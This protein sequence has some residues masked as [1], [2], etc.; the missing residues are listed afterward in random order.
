MKSKLVI[1]NVEKIT[2]LKYLNA[3][4]ITY[5]NKLGQEKKWELVSRQGLERLEKELYE[6]KVFSDGAMIFATNTE[7]THVVML[8][9]FRVSAGKYIYMVPAGLTDPGETIEQTSTRE[10]LE[11]TG[12]NFEFVKSAP[13]RYA[14]VG[15]VN[16]RVEI[17]YGYYHGIPNDHHMSVDEDA[18]VV[19]VDKEM[20]VQILATE[21]VSIR[22]ALLLEN[23][24]GLNDFF[25]K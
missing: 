11:E 10:F 5:L 25:R 17:A 4:E 9:E 12:M 14:S 13:P 3:F 21:D 24:F 18:Q 6:N 19:F 16:E 23:F 2:Q 8:R 20:A 1:K 15:I 7:K 22:T